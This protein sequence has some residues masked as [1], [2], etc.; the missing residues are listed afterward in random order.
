M[1]QTFIVLTSN[2]DTRGNSFLLSGVSIPDNLKI[3]KWFDNYQCVGVVLSHEIKDNKIFITAD[4]TEPVT[5][6]FP[7]IGFT[8]QKADSLNA[9]GSRF[10]EVTLT[11]IGVCEGRNSDETIPPLS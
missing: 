10:T 9:N 3:I 5:G 8:T 11:V 2:V 1:E 4:F 7:A 6:L